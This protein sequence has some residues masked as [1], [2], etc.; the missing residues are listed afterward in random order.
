VVLLGLLVSAAAAILGTLGAVRRA[1]Q[2]PPAEALRPEPPAT[3]R[4]TVLERW[5]LQ[6]LFSQ[7]ARMILR[8]LE[9]QPF[10]ALFSCVAIALAVAI[11]IVGSFTLDALD[12]MMDFQFALAQRQ[13]MTVALVEPS[14]ATALESLRHLPGV[15]HG[16]PFRSVPVRLRC[17][18]RT[19]RLA[20]MGLEPGSDLFRLIDDQRR[21]IPL[22]REGLL[23]SAKLAEILEVGVGEPLVVEVLEGARP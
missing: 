7:S 8:N 10:K 5:G 14:S 22:P 21:V 15:R 4:P 18:H 3:Y 23:L 11:L 13:D 16:E 6:G 9:R 20:V 19:R 12:Y 1:V 2:L 17:G